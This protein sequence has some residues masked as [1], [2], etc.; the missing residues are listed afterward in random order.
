MKNTYPFLSSFLLCLFLVFFGSC[1]T[2]K[3]NTRQAKEEIKTGAASKVAKELPSSPLLPAKTDDT[4]SLLWEISGNGLKK[5]S[6]LFGTIHLIAKKDFFMTDLVKDRFSRTSQL[7]L[8]IDM[9][10]PTMMLKMMTGMMMDGNKSLKDLVSEEDYKLLNSYFEESLGMGLGLF[11]RMKP[12]LLS[13]LMLEK[14]Q[15][16]VVSYENVFLE[17]A[18]K[19]KIPIEGLETAEY[20]LAML[21]SIPYEVQAQMLVDGL[22]EEGGNDDLFAQMVELYKQ[23]DLDALYNITM[24][25]GSEFGEYEGPLLQTRNKNWIPVIDEMSREQPTFFAVGAAHLAGE[26]GVIQLLKDEGFILTPLK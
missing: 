3:Q 21:D 8:E 9:D 16:E 1:K 6:Y 5:S 4:K 14:S 10:D 17:M 15:E 19:Q 18:Q 24:Q 12:I 20:Q 13:T 2:A 26:I 7:A 22:K 23:Q 25:E 11:D